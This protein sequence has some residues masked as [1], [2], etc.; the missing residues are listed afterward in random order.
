MLLARSVEEALLYLDINFCSCDRPRLELDGG[1]DKREDVFL[2]V[3]EGRC[4]RCGATGR[5]EFALDTSEEVPYPAIGGRTPSR[6][7]AP[8]EFLRVSDDAASRVP[9]DVSGLSSDEIAAARLLMEN[10]VTALEELRKFVPEGHVEVPRRESAS[11][12]ESAA[13]VGAPE[14]FRSE[15]IDERLRS[16][17]QALSQLADA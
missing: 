16:Y 1:M 10:A 4:D 6:I 8:E 12:A 3:Y 15:E 7:I 2:V 5:F 17:R 11:E 13:R 14:R 9:V